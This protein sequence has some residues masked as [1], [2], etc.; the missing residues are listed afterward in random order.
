MC[1]FQ[2]QL[3]PQE[4]KKDFAIVVVGSETTAEALKNGPPVLVG[5]KRLHFKPYTPKNDWFYQE[6]LKMEQKV[7]K[8]SQPQPTLAN[9]IL[10]PAYRTDSKG[11]PPVS[12]SGT[13]KWKLVLKNSSGVLC[14]LEKIE[15]LGWSPQFSI[16]DRPSMHPFYS[17]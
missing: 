8:I 16:D 7:A 6:A 13:A 15:K 17:F 10:I 14:H 5:S 9:S 4:G 12:L 11:D 3:T 2:L 1:L